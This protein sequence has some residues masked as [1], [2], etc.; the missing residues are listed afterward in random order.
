MLSDGL[1]NISNRNTTN[2]RSIHS[3]N[4]GDISASINHNGVVNL[5]VQ[6]KSDEDATWVSLSD[7][8][9]EWT[10][11]GAVDGTAITL[12]SYLARTDDNFRFK[13]VYSGSG[14]VAYPEIDYITYTWQSDVVA[15][16][17]PVVNTAIAA[18]ETIAVVQFDAL[19]SDAYAYQMD[20]NV[21]SAGSLPLSER[22]KIESGHN[23]LRL[24]GPQTNTE[25]EGERNDLAIALRGFANGDILDITS[26]A[27]DE[28]GNVS[29][30]TASTITLA[31]QST[32][33]LPGD[34]IEMTIADDII[35]MEVL[36]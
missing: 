9:D 36:P 21:N 29:A 27:R 18:N 10:D 8:P 26:Y 16:S 13:L 24:V 20:I 14:L 4:T 12:P 5:H 3:T 1:S 25:R 15:P 19:P 6:H 22:N 33:V 35:D 31:A 7:V 17:A 32:I 2:N 30:G 28:V 23:Y 34:L 11:L